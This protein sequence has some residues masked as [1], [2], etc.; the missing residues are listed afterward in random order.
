MWCLWI[1]RQCSHF[2]A[3]TQ[4]SAACNKSTQPKVYNNRLKS[5]NFLVRLSPFTYSYYVRIIARNHC[6]IGLRK[7]FQFISTQKQQFK[8]VS[9]IKQNFCHGDYDQKWSNELH[10]IL[11]VN[12]FLYFEQYKVETT[13]D[14]FHTF[15]GDN[16]LTAQVAE[17]E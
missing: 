6:T 5:G 10:L 17:R 9:G 2:S 12:S 1:F 16:F 15:R 3:Y 4:N 14:N 7:S 13:F 11:F 8:L